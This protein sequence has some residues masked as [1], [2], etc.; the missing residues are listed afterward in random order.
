MRDI[1]KYLYRAIIQSLNT[2]QIN[3]IGNLIDKNFDVGRLSGFGNISSIPKTTAA[4]TVI[5]YFNQSRDL[6]RYYELMLQFHGRFLYDSYIH[7]KNRHEFIKLLFSKGWIFDSDI[8]MFLQDPFLVEDIN[9]LESIKNIDLRNQFDFSEIMARISRVA[10][11]LRDIDIEWHISM[12]MYG[13]TKEVDSLMTGLLELLLA[14]QNLTELTF[15]IFFCLRELAVNAGKAGYKTLYEKYMHRHNVETG[16]SDYEETL[17][18]FRDEIYENRDL[19]LIELARQEDLYFDLY[20]NS[21]KHSISVWT[22]NY[23]PIT[24]VEK[25]RLLQRLS[26]STFNE[27]DSFISLDDKHAEGAGMGIIM[28]MNILRSL[29]PGKEPLKVVFYPDSTKIGFVLFR[30]DMK[31]NISLL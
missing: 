25:I 4:E 9:F 24:K 19:R 10:K 17:R 21:N 7:V 18:M 15:N 12:R 27:E 14:K 23:T 29:Y 6:I 20:F 16:E 22:Q 11:K 26:I 13:L 5:R 3:H 1:K 8:M 31:E 28:V 2:D 30:T